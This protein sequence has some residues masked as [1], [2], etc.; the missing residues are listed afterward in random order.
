MKLHYFI[1]AFVTNHLNETESSQIENKHLLPLPPLLVC[2]SF[3]NL[4]ISMGPTVAIALCSLSMS[5]SIAPVP[6]LPVRFV[7]QAERC[8]ALA[9][10]LS[11][12]SG[13]VL[14]ILTCEFKS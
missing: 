8:L 11:A 2:P 7:L 14:N 4:S 13:V 12:L 10:L 9:N 1:S 6:S 5:M 3:Y